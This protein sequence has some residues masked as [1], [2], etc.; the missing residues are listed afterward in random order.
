MEDKG[1]NDEDTWGVKARFDLTRKG[2]ASE[3]S[4]R[5]FHDLRTL[6]DGSD[7]NVDNLFLQYRYQLS[8]RFGMGINGRLVLSYDLFNNQDNIQDTRYYRL[9]PF[10]FYRLTENL[11]AYLRYSFENN[12]ED[13][14]DNENSRQRSRV[15]IQFKYELPMML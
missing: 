15:W 10:L 13:L 4:F 5:Y 11:N 12:S 1:G 3:I 14:I 7:V 8:A 6:T 9:E 2:I